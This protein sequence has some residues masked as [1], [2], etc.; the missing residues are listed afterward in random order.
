MTMRHLPL[1]VGTLAAC[2]SMAPASPPEWHFEF[3]GGVPNKLV[4]QSEAGH[5]YDLEFS[6]DLVYWNRLVGYPKPGSGSPMEIPFTVGVNV[7]LRGFFKITLDPAVAGFVLV[8]AGSFAMGDSFD[9]EGETDEIPV[10]SV[11]V[12]AFYMG[13]YPVT[14]ALWDSVR[15]WGA[16]HAY[17]DLPVGGGKAGEHPVHSVDWFEAVK[18]CNARSEM[19]DLDPCY[20]V[21]GAVY[22][23]G[24]GASPICDWDVNGYRLPT[25][26]EWEK[27]A[28]GGLIGK[29]FPWGDTINHSHANYVADGSAHTYDT[30]GT[31]KAT[32]HPDWD[33]D[34]EPYTSPVGTFAPN[35]YGLYD[36][37]GNVWEWCWDWLG[38]DYYD[39]APGTD[40]RGPGSGSTRTARGGSWQDGAWGVRCAQRGTWN[41]GNENDTLGFRLV[42]SRP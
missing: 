12:S 40:P 31:T 9:P 10:H 20:T 25:E 38:I 23:T 34:P 27:A 29:R 4:W 35:A 24:S 37:A 6:E 18:W 8:P 15:T 3:S 7:G 33:D 41:P 2:F 1:L 16:T 17:T 30:S 36:M 11:V 28:R 13:Q 21:A 26:A 5:F 22:R 39:N 14:K 32:S 42:R 19:D